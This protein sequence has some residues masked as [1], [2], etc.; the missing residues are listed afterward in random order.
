MH[1]LKAWGENRKRANRTTR[2]NHC[3]VID[4]NFSTI[5][6]LTSWELVYQIVYG[7]SKL[8]REYKVAKNVRGM[9]QRDHLLQSK[10][11]RE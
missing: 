2:A 7:V 10:D 11:A 6:K 4:T 1:F 5:L 9:T 8:L 3:K